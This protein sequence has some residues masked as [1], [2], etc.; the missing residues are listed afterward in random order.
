M[1]NDREYKKRNAACAKDES[2]ACKTFLASSAKARAQMRL[3][4]RLREFENTELR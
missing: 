3:E 1:W 2:D 4:R